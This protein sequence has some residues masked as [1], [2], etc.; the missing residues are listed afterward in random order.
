MVRATRYF[1]PIDHDKTVENAKLVLKD[2][3]YHKRRA[4][5]KKPSLRSPIID[6]MPKSPSADNRAEAALTNYSNE[7]EYATLCEN[8]IYAITNDTYRVIMI[9]NYLVSPEH[10]K[11]WQLIASTVHLE[12]SSYYDNLKDALFE[13]SIHCRLVEIVYKKT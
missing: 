1:S 7:T 5:A 9:E 10:R 2:Y 13:F 3:R 4:R 12:R 8:A 6:G 11:P